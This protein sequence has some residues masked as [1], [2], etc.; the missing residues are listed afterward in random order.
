MKYRPSLAWM[1]L[2]SSPAR[3]P[4]L[5]QPSR[6][7]HWRPHRHVEAILV[8]R[9]SSQHLGSPSR[10]HPHRTGPSH[11]SGSGGIQ[12]AQRSAGGPAP[13]SRARGHFVCRTQRCS[14]DCKV[15]YPRLCPIV[16]SAARFTLASAAGCERGEPRHSCKVSAS[17]CL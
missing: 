14:V 5:R 11:T 13:S 1:P 7:P 3:S 12:R 8:H 17:L 15:T 10:R 2:D 4:C 9:C 6:S 16:L